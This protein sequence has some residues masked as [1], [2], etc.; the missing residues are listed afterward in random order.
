MRKGLFYTANVFLILALLLISFGCN[1]GLNEEEATGSLSVGFS[2]PRSVDSDLDTSVAS[3]DI[4]LTHTV[5]ETI[6]NLSVEKG[7]AIMFTDLLTG[8]W[9][10]AVDALN[11]AG[12]CIADGSAYVDVN[13]N[14]VSSVTILL[15]W[16]EG[17]GLFSLSIGWTA[18]LLVAPVTVSAD[19]IPMDGGDLICLTLNEVDSSAACDQSVPVGLYTLIVSIAD[20][21]EYSS[22]RVEVVNVMAG[23]AT[24]AEFTFTG[25]SGNSG[26]V[27]TDPVSPVFTFSLTTDMDAAA[28][29]ETI[30]ASV[31]V[32]DADSYSWYADYL[33][34]EGEAT[35]TLA[36]TSDTAKTVHLTCVV[37]K[38]G[39]WASESA[40]IR[41]GE[42]DADLSTQYY[43]AAKRMIDQGM[44]TG[45]PVFAL[46]NVYSLLNQAVATNPD[47]SDAVL[48]L[49]VLDLCG[50]LIEDD[51]QI[52]MKG[53]LGLERY[54]DTYAELYSNIWTLAV[55]YM[56]GGDPA[57]IDEYSTW[58]EL[59]WADYDSDDP[60]DI[61]GEE[62]LLN[63]PFLAGLAPAPG[64]VG[65]DEYFLQ[66][67]D[68]MTSGGK[69]LDDVT[70]GIID[71]LG[72]SLDAVT[73]NLGRL[74]DD[75]RFEVSTDTIN[76]G[77]PLP[78]GFYTSAETKI[79]AAALYQ[80]EMF[81]YLT[82]AVEQGF[83]IQLLLDSFMYNTES[84]YIVEIGVDYSPF[85]D[86]FLGV[87]NDDVAVSVAKAREAF[88]T[89]LSLIKEGTSEIAAREAEGTTEVPAE[90]PLILSPDGFMGDSWIYVDDYFL[91]V[92]KIAEE[93]EN[94][95]VNDVEAILPFYWVKDPSLI[96]TYVQDVDGDGVFENWPTEVSMEF[97]SSTEDWSFIPDGMQSVGINFSRIFNADQTLF[98]FLLEL[99]DTGDLQLYTFDGR[100]PSVATVFDA[101]TPYYFCIPDLTL[102]GFIP[103]SSIPLSEAEI[104]AMFD[105]NTPEVEE[106]ASFVI[107]NEDGSVSWYMSIILVSTMFGDDSVRYPFAYHVLT[108]ITERGT[109]IMVRTPFPT[110]RE[111]RESEVKDIEEGYYFDT[112]LFDAPISVKSKGTFWSALDDFVDWMQLPIQER[113]EFLG[114]FEM[115]ESNPLEL[116]VNTSFL[117]YSDSYFYPADGSAWIRYTVDADGIF[118]LAATYYTAEP[119]IYKNDVQLDSGG[120][121][122]RIEV[123]AGDEILVHVTNFNNEIRS[124]VIMDD[125]LG[126]V[127]TIDSAYPL[128]ADTPVQGRVHYYLSDDYFTF[129]P[130]TDRV[131]ITLTAPSEP[132]GIPEIFNYL[133][134]DYEIW[135]DGARAVNLCNVETYEVDVYAA[136]KV[137]SIGV[138][139]FDGLDYELE[140]EDI[141]TPF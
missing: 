135:I 29:G 92:G 105:Y 11:S 25:T 99:D 119:E 115:T 34:I 50:F 58:S 127:R 51:I 112:I 49:S 106:P 76:P 68:N 63:L 84:G 19:L 114:S 125:T 4:T 24:S 44:E 1:L 77:L 60:D 88:L 32:T 86:G 122:G 21:G 128:E 108:D 95:V 67:L 62:N 35:Y 5:T 75:A 100:T 12:I 8:Q 61:T 136:E 71:A 42:Y 17:S 20:S 94:S 126:D 52:V 13:A 85:A 23:A 37:E 9:L 27:V 47:N 70:D 87:D 10:V 101:E 43:L 107:E 54:P 103:F 72:S 30:T 129:T 15:S 118:T 33:P 7:D 116:P 26:V 31:D 90:E 64:G 130:N 80:V 120:D 55:W 121:L 78:M 89:A 113:Y 3:Y 14:S 109:G 73:K 82:K 110:Y 40:E 57:I 28:V 59:I 138:S 132:E 65:P 53:M 98:N 79:V 134:G 91:F 41:F 93:V 102:G 39:Q 140:W 66:M 96:A 2:T 56:S 139:D 46:D 117:I 48:A 97:T 36:Y 81:A 124:T 137:F 123:A 133:R 22:G 38:D 6:K 141:G 111:Y 45:A 16:L 83:D 69:D 131:R 74:S 18:E 104:E